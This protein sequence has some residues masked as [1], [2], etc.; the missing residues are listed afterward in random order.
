[1][2]VRPTMGA[3]V[4]LSLAAAAGFLGGLLAVYVTSRERPWEETRDDRLLL[5]DASPIAAR[6]SLSLLEERPAVAMDER[7]RPYTT[8]NDIDDDRRKR[9]GDKPSPLEEPKPKPSG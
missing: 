7:Q 6:H 2:E 9:A 8:M 1:M 5:E 3:A 4:R